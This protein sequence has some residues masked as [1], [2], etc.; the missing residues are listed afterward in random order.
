M[1]KLISILLLSVISTMTMASVGT[2]LFTIKK[3]MAENKGVDRSLA[4]GSALDV[5]DTIITAADASAKIKY[6]NGTLVTIGESSTYKIVAYSPSQEEVLKAELSKGKIESQTN[7]GAKKEALKTPMVALAITG[8]KYKAYVPN[9]KKTNV[10]LIEGIIKIDNKVLQPGE[11]IVATM[12]GITPAPYPSA[13]NIVAPPE[14]SS[15]STQSSSSSTTSGGTS[16]TTTTSGNTSTAT[17][18]AGSQESGAATTAFVNTTTVVSQT[19]AAST[20]VVVPNINPVPT[21]SMEC[22]STVP[23]SIPSS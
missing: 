18:A 22:L 8:T 6:N 9:N 11:S 10:F 21:F 20:P 1:K 4:R 2:V 17:T 15:I 5:G 16:T 7:G 12:Y 3:V 14:M 19:T 23:T 13:G